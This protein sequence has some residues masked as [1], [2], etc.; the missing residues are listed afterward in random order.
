MLSKISSWTVAVA[1]AAIVIVATATSSILLHETRVDVAQ[2]QM[3]VSETRRTVDR[4]WGNHLQADQRS[5]A[6]D[7]FFA[8][9]LLSSA[10]RSFLLGKVAY[11]LRGAALSMRAASGE[12]VSDE[13]AAEIAAFEKQLGEGDARGY[14][15]LKEEI[16]RL[17]LGSQDRINGLADEIRVMEARVEAGRTRESWIYLAYVFFNLLGLMITMCKDLPIWKVNSRG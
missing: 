4:L 13:V 5:T 14:V 9:A 3:K 10:N 12:S 1:G 15:S 6:A 7:V 16:D 2:A 8:Q 11:Q 17:R